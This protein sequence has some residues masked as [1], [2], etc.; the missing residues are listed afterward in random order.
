MA[1]NITVSSPMKNPERISRSLGVYAGQVA[2]SS[3]ALTLIECTAI[4]D[5]FVDISH[6]NATAA[7]FPLSFLLM[8]LSSTQLCRTSVP[9]GYE[10]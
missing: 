5:K 10:A 6:T 9:A 7:L 8:S 2:M 4:T 1:F 3:Y